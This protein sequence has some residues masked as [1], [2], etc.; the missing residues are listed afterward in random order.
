MRSITIGALLWLDNDE[1]RAGFLLIETHGFSEKKCVADAIDK[2]THF[3]LWH[4]T[5]VPNQSSH[6]RYQG[7]NRPRPPPETGGQHGS[8]VPAGWA[9]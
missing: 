3:R 2:S 9:A 4:E 6:V 8:A 5:D 1:N 7:M